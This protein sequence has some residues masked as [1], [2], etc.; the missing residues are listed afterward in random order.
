MSILSKI[1]PVIEC[2]TF[3]GQDVSAVYIDT[4]GKYYIAFGSDGYQLST[5]TQLLELDSDLDCAWLFRN[6]VK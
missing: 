6:L 4:T 5:K 3:E 2:S 1:L